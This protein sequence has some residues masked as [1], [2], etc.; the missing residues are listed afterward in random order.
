M[1]VYHAGYLTGPVLTAQIPEYLI[2]GT[3]A[4]AAGALATHG[5]AAAHARPGARPPT[6][7]LTA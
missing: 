1:H 4:E 5:V 3:I 6:N 7:G 2:N